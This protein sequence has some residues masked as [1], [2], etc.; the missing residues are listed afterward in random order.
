[1]GHDPATDEQYEAIT[2][3]IDVCRLNHAICN[4]TVSASHSFDVYQ[5]PLPSR[6]IEISA[7]GNNLRLV[8]SAGKNGTYIAVT[9]RWNQQT[10]ESKTTLQNYQSRLSGG[11]FDDLPELYRHF[12]T[13]ARRLG[14]HYVWIDS[15][16]IIQNGDGGADWQVEAPKMA[17]Y[18][19][20]S[21]LTIATTRSDAKDGILR[22]VQ[23][24]ASHPWSQ[25]CL[26]RL[27]YRDRNGTVSGHM[28][29]Y[30]RKTRL[31]DDYY[32]HVV[33]SH[34]MHRGWIL[35]EWLLSKRIVWYTAGGVI[36]EC[37]ADNPMTTGQERLD[38]E[39]A[40][41]EL[42][43]HL[44]LKRSFS[45]SNMAILDFWYRSIEVYSSCHLTKPDQDH[46]LAV[47]GLAKEVHHI[48]THSPA[49]NL[50]VGPHYVA[51]L[52][53]PDIHH[54]LLWQEAPEAAR[55]RGTVEAASSWSWAHVLTEV[56]WPERAPGR[57]K[58]LEVL[59]VCLEKRDEHSEPVHAYES[60]T[61]SATPFAFQPANL[62]SCLHVRGRI[63]V[64]HVR[65]YLGTEKNLEVAA[66][67]T[68]CDPK[69]ASQTWRAVCSPAQ[70]EVIAGWGSL[71]QLRDAE[72]GC[73]D[74]GTAVN[75]LAVST[76]TASW[77]FVVSRSEP[78]LDVLFLQEVEGCGCDG[79][80][81]RLGVGRISDQE[82]IEHILSSPEQAV[83]LV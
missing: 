76:R 75:V 5:S 55:P 53:L 82:F 8:E 32:R 10:E 33:D 9:H 58:C 25:G 4:Q 79:K 42:Q 49:L 67:S 43:A 40:T 31:S 38:A 14:V 77:G 74:Y 15:L 83:Q 24:E 26:A 41:P 69:F 57:K 1:M 19:Q 62:F 7:D 20:F 72:P 51:G 22:Q 6:V 11:S 39:T 3:W 78:V 17:H 60:L 45:F 80:Y 52:W 28:Y 12:F 27:P 23:P 50:R 16:C 21:M 70:P 44:T 61:R 63:S 13:I 64:A 54:G 34:L 65:G 68:A 46:V 56:R 36:L 59:G 48:I 35:Q 29:A 30:K 37:Q 47:A 81:R 18:Y 66:K 2:E 73:A 71:E